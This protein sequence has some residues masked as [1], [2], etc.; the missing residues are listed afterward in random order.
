MKIEAETWR[1]WSPHVNKGRSQESGIVRNNIRISERKQKRWGGFQ[2]LTHFMRTDGLFVFG[3]GKKNEAFLACSS[4]VQLSHPW[5][6]RRNCLW[7][8]NCHLS[9][10][11][12]EK[13]ASKIPPFGLSTHPLEKTGLLVM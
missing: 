12:H 3:P 6:H 5:T 7:I 13:N 2:K 4:C 1:L 8:P 11:V 10:C 9:Q